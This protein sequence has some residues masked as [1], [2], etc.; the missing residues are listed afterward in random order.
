MT[1]KD[2]WEAVRAGRRLTFHDGDDPHWSILSTDGSQRYFIEFN[3]VLEDLVCTCQA[4]E[5]PRYCWHRTRVRAWLEAR[6]GPD[7]PAVKLKAATM[8]QESERGEAVH[9]PVD[10]SP[11]DIGSL[12]WLDVAKEASHG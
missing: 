1:V 7:E 11:A 3:P 6:Y 5:S 4:G 10:P 9:V 12:S 8:P 2:G